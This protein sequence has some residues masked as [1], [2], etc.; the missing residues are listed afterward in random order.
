MLKT[1]PKSI[2]VDFTFISAFLGLAAMYLIVLRGSPFVLSSAGAV[3]FFSLFGILA[4]GWVVCSRRATS[5]FASEENVEVTKL[6]RRK[7]F[8][9]LVAL[10]LL[11]G[12]TVVNFYQPLKI[13]FWYGAD[14]FHAFIPAPIW[15]AS[16]DIAQSRPLLSLA[17]HLGSILTPGRIEGFLWLAVAL[18]LFNG[19][20]VAAIIRSAT[21]L[22][23]YVA[24]T[25][26]LLFVANRADLARFAPLW[27][28][29]TYCL[30]VLFFLLSVWLLLVSFQSHSRL[31]LTVSCCLVVISLLMVEGGY[32]LVLFGPLFL[33]FKKNRQQVFLWLFAWMGAVTLAAVRLA[34]FLLNTRGQS[35]QAAS[36]AAVL[37][38]PAS[39]F[40]NL[41]SHLLAPLAYFKDFSVDGSEWKWGLLSIVLTAL[42]IWLVVSPAGQKLPARTW[43]TSM[44][45]AL[46]ALFLGALPF[47]PVSGL[48]R[49]HFFAAPADAALVAITLGFFGSLFPQRIGLWIFGG[50][51]CVL[52]GHSTVASLREQKAAIASQ[53]VYF[54]KT[55]HIFDQVHS[56]S[57]KFAPDSLIVFILDDNIPS[58]L[59]LNYGVYILAEAVL[60]TPA[61]QANFT[62]I[63]PLDWSADFAMESIVITMPSPG[64]HPSK[65]EFRYDQVVAF[66]LTADGNV[67]LLEKL[68]D[69]LLPEGNSGE[70]YAPF[71]RMQPGPVDE[72]K[73]LRYPSWAEKLPD[74]FDSSSGTLLVGAWAPLQLQKDNLYRD[75]GTGGLIAI[76]PLGQSRRTLSLNIKPPESTGSWELQALDKNNRPTA[77]AP[78]L[79]RQSVELAVPLDPNQINIFKLRLIETRPSHDDGA[80][81]TAFRIYCKGKFPNLTHRPRGAVEDVVSPGLRLG[82]NWYPLEG[83]D[84]NRF[85]WVDNDAEIVV[86]SEWI[87]GAKL[88]L[89]V[90]PGPGVGG[91]PF[92]L[93]VIDSDGHVLSQTEITGR[94]EVRCLLPAATRSKRIYRL[95]AVGGGAPSP[96]G[97][98]RILNFCVLKVSAR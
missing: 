93:Q 84:G 6:N 34:L 31:L 88:M 46:L 27:A 24:A 63:T 41:K 44:G 51:T 35:Y 90:Q 32:F 72:L 57:P 71:A 15:S 54:E 60:G 80:V 53:N 86:E 79:K 14:D 7:G 39:M 59:R 36:T 68:P 33:I 26:A 50:L 62:D 76:N 77:S 92:Q 45:G 38:S 81:E 19:L 23:S 97:D 98:P 12:I 5:A 42:F 95:H 91:N 52:V 58:P 74:V 87:E 2:W 94:Q 85:R 48:F 61:V 17:P 83:E 56:L 69:R 9:P 64:G 11:T 21:P 1:A 16:A 43:W 22:P 78:V 75:A 25:T 55:V 66:R 13:L 40:E 67:S 89:T 96:G 49:T 47:L 4:L 37:K 20:L 28:S 18:C 30:S 65:R 70:S 29:N 10:A 73:Y 8:M 82:R 3:V